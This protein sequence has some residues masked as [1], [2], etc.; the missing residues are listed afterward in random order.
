LEREEDRDTMNAMAIAIGARMTAD[1]YLALGE[2]Y[3]RTQLI[4]GEVV[5]Y[6]PSP[7]HQHVCTDLLFALLMW[8][9]AES[10]RGFAIMPLDVRLDDRNVYGPDLL[11]YAEGRGPGPAGGR[12]SPMPDVAVEVR[13]PSTWRY[14]V[15]VKLSVY[16]RQGLA[17]LWLVD[18]RASTVL[19]FRRS[20]LETASFDV[21]L[22]LELG[23]D[24]TSPQL[25][26]FSL[27]LTELFRQ[28][29]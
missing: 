29:D 19:V 4:E 17:E 3:P 28:A 25:P 6:E 22:E 13:S 1:A 26:G 11:W 16:E 21:R 5:L 18:T 24:L 9:R 20:S 2:D 12:P 7:Q 27:A 10:G 14:D 15:G 23:E 8:S